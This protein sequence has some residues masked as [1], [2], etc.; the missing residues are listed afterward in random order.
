MVKRNRIYPILAVLIALAFVQSCGNDSGSSPQF[1]AKD[2]ADRGW[3]KF[4]AADYSGASAD[5]NQAISTDA[6]YVDGYLGAGWA[7]YFLND[8]A[9]ARPKFSTGRNKTDNAALIGDFHAGLTLSWVELGQY[10]KCIAEAD[11]C[12][13]I[14][15]QYVF[16][17]RSTINYTDILAAKAKAYFLLGGDANLKVAAGL[18]HDIIPSINLDPD[19]SSSWRVTG[20][21]YDT[22]SE[23]LVRALEE[24]AKIAGAS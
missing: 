9:N 16:S 3:Q 1:T 17:H 14:S 13:E 7:N 4:V 10:E 5:F 11:S 21:S 15:P 6:A 8:M 18:V 12:M 23:A 20:Q 24:A 2:H 22:F 19:N